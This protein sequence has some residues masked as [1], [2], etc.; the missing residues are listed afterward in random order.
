MNWL[1]DTDVDILPNA[2]T[3]IDL[4]NKRTFEITCQDCGQSASVQLTGGPMRARGNIKTELEKKNGHH[5]LKAPSHNI[6]FDSTIVNIGHRTTR[7][8]RVGMENVQYP[9]NMR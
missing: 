1:V 8:I 9:N 3:K 4:A 6:D 7:I 2:K 5:H